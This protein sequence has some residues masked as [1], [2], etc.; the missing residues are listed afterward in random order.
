MMSGSRTVFFRRHPICRA[1]NGRSRH[2]EFCRSGPIAEMT[3]L[4]KHCG[5]RGRR[6]RLSVYLGETS[7]IGLA[8]KHR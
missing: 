3:D 7:W 2:F 6:D 4:M 1:K 8:R 5:Y